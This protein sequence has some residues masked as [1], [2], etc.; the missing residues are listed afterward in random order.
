MK[1]GGWDEMVSAIHTVM[2]VYCIIIVLISITMEFGAAGGASIPNDIMLPMLA[3]AGCGWA[4][5]FLAALASQGSRTGKVM[6]CLSIAS[7]LT[8]LGFLIYDVFGGVATTM[9]GVACLLV[10]V[11]IFCVRKS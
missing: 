11:G 7:G 3:W 8:L 9:F 4:A 10:A 6:D 1:P 5:F 2:V